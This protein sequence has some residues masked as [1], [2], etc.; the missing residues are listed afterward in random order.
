MTIPD[1]AREKFDEVWGH[2]PDKIDTSR[3][4]RILFNNPCGPRLQSDHLGTQ[5]SLSIVES[6]GVGGLCLAETNLNWGNAAAYTQVQSLLRQTWGNH[7]LTYS[8]LK[9]Y[10]TLWNQPGGTATVIT[11]NWTSRIL[12]KGMDPFGLGRWSYFILRGE[13]GIKVLLITAYRVCVQSPMLSGPKTS[14][15]QQFRKLSEKH[16]SAEY[17]D[18]PVPRRQFVIDLHAWIQHMQRTSHNIIL[19]IDANEAISDEAGQVLSLEYTLDKPI[20]D[21]KHDGTIATLVRSCGLQ[22]P[23]LKH[24]SDNP[25]PTYTRGKDRI[26]FIFTS[27][28]TMAACIMSGL[29]P[30]H[31]I[32]MGDHIA[33]Y[34]DFDGLLLFQEN[35]AAIEPPKY[36]GLQCHDPRI[37]SKYKDILHKYIG[38]HKL[39]IKVSALLNKVK[40]NPEAASILGE[41]E[42]LDCLLTAGMLRAEK[43][44]SRKYS[45]TYHWS[46]PLLWAV[47]TL[48][49]WKLQ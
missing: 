5:Y 24:H 49:Y 27:P 3:T 39:N 47:Q 17:V 26:D 41:Y 20:L 12:E 10:F 6:L 31:S 44:V 21:K 34:L 25:P 14:T 16:R 40:E 42:K 28:R 23:L 35:T 37:V 36:Q 29:F 15:S 45:K 48:L 9:E 11:N 19:C 33:C 2:Y 38:Y 18:D 1:S 30:F 46:P 7:S 43:Q 8:H 22:D 32:F 4:I 13:S